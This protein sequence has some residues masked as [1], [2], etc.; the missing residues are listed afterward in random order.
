MDDFLQGGN[1]QKSART[2]TIEDTA[3]PAVSPANA[4]AARR[5]PLLRVGARPETAADTVPVVRT[6]DVGT[7][8]RSQYYVANKTTGRSNP[9]AS[10]KCEV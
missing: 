2:R 6:R 7:S 5:G 1:E 4:C 9:G 3:A 10:W 8:P